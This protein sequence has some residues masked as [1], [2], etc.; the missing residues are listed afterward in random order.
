MND[1]TNKRWEEVTERLEA[2]EREAEEH[3][4]NERTKAQAFAKKF[5]PAYSKPALFYYIGIIVIGIAVIVLVLLG[6]FPT[7]DTA[8]KIQ[9]GE[10]YSGK[11]EQGQKY[12]LCLTDMAVV[13]GGKVLIKDTDGK[14]YAADATS[15]DK[16]A[17]K[18]IKQEWKKV[19]TFDENTDGEEAHTNA[20]YLMEA[21]SALFG[22]EVIAQFGN[23]IIVFETPE[24]QLEMP[25]NTSLDAYKGNDEYYVLEG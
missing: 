14:Y 17:E 10:C 19:T 6:M 21:A 23:Q 22:K 13:S 7:N 18:I 2:G 15:K 16:E 5:N 8:Q 4:K 9:N 25:A 3:A 1:K 11:V 24:F 12:D 20:L